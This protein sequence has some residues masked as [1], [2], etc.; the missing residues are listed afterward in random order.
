[1]IRLFT[2]KWLESLDTSEATEKKCYWTPELHPRSNLLRSW[3]DHDKL[4]LAGIREDAGARA[5]WS[6]PSAHR[7]AMLCSYQRGPPVTVL[8]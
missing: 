4:T 5:G 7:G 8:R 1:M 3:D 6:L 2:P